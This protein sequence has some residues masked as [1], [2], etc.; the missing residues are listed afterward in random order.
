MS[1]G[2]RPVT[3]ADQPL[4]L[5]LYAATRAEEL[6]RVPWPPEQKHAFVQMQFTAQTRHYEAH[7]P[8]SAHEMVL[9]EGEEVGRLWVDRNSEA[10]HILDLTISP[11]RRGRGIGAAV[12]Q[13]L[14][15]EGAEAG[16]PITIY[17]EG[18]SPAARLFGR[19]GFTKVEEQGFHHLYRWAPASTAN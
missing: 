6:A 19:L 5:E 18:W 7:H 11:G 15:A 8:H 10:I 9:W 1:L 16:R 12:L 3:D 13:R 14:L 2:F 17:L 4:L